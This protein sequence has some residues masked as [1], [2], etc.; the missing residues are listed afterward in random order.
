MNR[1]ERTE[2]FH[3]AIQLARWIESMPD[4]LRIRTR[5]MV[6]RSTARIT[7]PSSWFHET[8]EEAPLAGLDPWG[9]IEQ[10][11]RPDGGVLLG[12]KGIGPATIKELRQALPPPGSPDIPR[13]LP[14]SHHRTGSSLLSTDPAVTMLNELWVCLEPRERLRTVELAAELV[15]N[16]CQQEDA[17]EPTE[18]TVLA[19]AIKRRLRE[20]CLANAEGADAQGAV[21]K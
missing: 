9:F 11:H 12:V 4:R 20:A 13:Y 8:P 15:I 2:D 18:D 1:F 21:A 16:R 6:L 17:P 5:N 3:R 10:L 14:S 19:E 7:R